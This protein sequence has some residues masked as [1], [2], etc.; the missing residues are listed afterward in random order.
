MNELNAATNNQ[1]RIYN[2]QRELKENAEC[3]VGLIPY[4]VNEPYNDVECREVNCDY[5]WFVLYCKSCRV[6]AVFAINNVKVLKK[7]SI[8]LNMVA[9]LYRHL[10][11]NVQNVVVMIQIIDLKIVI[12]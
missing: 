4:E 12:L 3:K 10:V 6:V 8:L 5:G 2:L 11:M 9:K 1:M 7:A